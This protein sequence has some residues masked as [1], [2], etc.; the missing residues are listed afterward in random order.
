MLKTI[1]FNNFQIIN[2]EYTLENIYINLVFF[3]RLNSI[4][5]NLK[6]ILSNEERITLIENFKIVDSSDLE[7]IIDTLDNNSVKLEHITSEVNNSKKIFD[8]GF[9]N[10]LDILSQ[11]KKYFQ[12]NNDKIKLL[13][14]FVFS[15]ETTA[16]EAIKNL[17]KF[18]E[19]AKNLK[20]PVF[21][22]MF[23]KEKVAKLVNDFKFV[24]FS[25]KQEYINKLSFVESVLGLFKFIYSKVQ[26]SKDKDAQFIDI[27]AM[28]KSNLDDTQIAELRQDNH[29][30]IE[31]NSIG[32]VSAIVNSIKTVL[33]NF[34]I[35]NSDK[36]VSL[37]KDMSG[38]YKFTKLIEIEGTNRNEYINFCI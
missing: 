23:K 16:T 17:E 11:S 10:Y 21:G 38:F 5:S 9:N 18:I 29:S 35:I 33:P 1:P 20:M 19:D 36:Y 27:L 6:N 2:E 32:K 30:I 15:K 12:I 7:L 28:L 37:I 31:K 4:Y 22:F 25:F 24:F 14:D 8:E 26:S 13:E 3:D 34:N